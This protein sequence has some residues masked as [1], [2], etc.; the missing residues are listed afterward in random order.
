MRAFGEMIRAC[1]TGRK[2]PLRKVAAY[3]DIDQA[4]LSKIERGKRTATREQVLKLSQYFEV[5]ENDFLI[6]WL[7][8]KLVYEVRNETFAIQAL[9]VAEEKIEYN[10]FL[11]IDRVQL[12]KK[13]KEGFLNFPG[14]E[15]A[16]VYGSFSRGEDGPH[17]DIDIAL[18]T[19]GE[20]SYF[21]LA[22]V[23][24]ELESLV[25]RKVDVGFIDSFKPYILEHVKP[26]LKVIYEK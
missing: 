6:A 15:K 9:Q 22:Q 13:I 1:R 25:K 19:S 24:F 17:S 12:L 7:S 8:D 11:K 5:S 3:L 20:F 14:I 18:K 2:F 23:Q 10:S 26:D 4:I 21:D 16:W